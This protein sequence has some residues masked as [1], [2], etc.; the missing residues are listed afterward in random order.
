MNITSIDNPIS[1]HT[2]I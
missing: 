1:K 2:H